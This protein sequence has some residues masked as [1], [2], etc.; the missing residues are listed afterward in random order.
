MSDAFDLDRFAPRPTKFTLKG[1]EYRVSGDPDVDVV[2]R[3]LRVEDAI[4]QSGDSRETVEAVEE[5]RD[6]LLEMVQEQDPDVT[7]LKLGTTQLLVVFALIIHGPSVAAAVLAA[8]ANPSLIGESDD[9]PVTTPHDGDGEEVER[10]EDEDADPLAL[11]QRSPRRSSLLVT[12]DAGL[13]DTG[14]D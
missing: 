11:G 9:S 5:G 7:E 4:R 12:A 2:A 14:S 3:M 1:R 8:I 10:S 13:P 6:L